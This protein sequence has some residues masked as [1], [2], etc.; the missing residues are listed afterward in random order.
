MNPFQGKV[1]S[2][3]EG[4]DKQKA[5]YRPDEEPVERLPA[6]SEKRL[7]GSRIKLSSRGPHKQHKRKAGRR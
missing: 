6:V 4:R 1:Q 5:R 7:R 3:S 2:M